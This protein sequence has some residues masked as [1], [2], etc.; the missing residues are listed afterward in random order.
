MKTFT[1]FGLA[2]LAATALPLDLAYGDEPVVPSDATAPAPIASPA[3]VSPTPAAPV[4]ETKPRKRRHLPAIK[5]STPP[6]EKK[7]Q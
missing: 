2:L 3:P 6:T 1:R 5:K 4:K 7:T